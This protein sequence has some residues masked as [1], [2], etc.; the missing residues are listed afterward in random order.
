MHVITRSTAHTSTKRV[1]CVPNGASCNLDRAWLVHE[2]KQSRSCRGCLRA[3]V[4]RSRRPRGAPA[5]RPAPR[6]CLGGWLKKE[7]SR[8]FARSRACTATAT[9]C[10]TQPLLLGCLA[11]ARSRAGNS[12]FSQPCARHSPS[13]LAYA[14]IAH[15]A[16]VRMH[17][18]ADP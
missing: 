17:T 16:C 15:R 14:C 2:S 13:F 4:R 1:H 12:K 8:S 18:Q 3:Y 9:S 6:P 5:R 10:L 7:A 11:F